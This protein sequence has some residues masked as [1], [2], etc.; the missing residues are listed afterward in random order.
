MK[1]SNKSLLIFAAVALVVAI[2]GIIYTSNQIEDHIHLTEDTQIKTPYDD[3]IFKIPTEI[4][5]YDPE[6]VTLCSIILCNTTTLN[7]DDVVISTSAHPDNTFTSTIDADDTVNILIPY[8]A[9]SDAT[10][11]SVALV[12]RKDMQDSNTTPL[13]SYHVF[14]TISLS[15]QSGA[16]QASFDIGYTDLSEI[17][18]MLWIY[19]GKIEAYSM[20]QYTMQNTTSPRYLAYKNPDKTVHEFTIQYGE[21]STTY[22]FFDDGNV[23]FKDWVH[24][25]SNI[26]S[27]IAF[28]HYLVDLQHQW[29]VGLD[30]VVIKDK[31]VFTAIPF[32]EAAIQR[33]TFDT[34]DLQSLASWLGKSRE[35]L[36]SHFG[37]PNKIS[38]DT[39]FS[40]LEYNDFIATVDIRNRIVSIELLTDKYHPVSVLPSEKMTGL[41]LS[42]YCLVE[43]I[44]YPSAEIF[45]DE[46]VP[47]YRTSVTFC[48]E[49]VSISYLWESEKPAV[50]ATEK[51]NRIIIHTGE[52]IMY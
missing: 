10:A 29:M 14:K 21:N 47:Y 45:K 39:A 3:I 1:Q 40:H 34:T 48:N 27:W 19:D 17:F 49:D 43:G 52:N 5:D 22:G 8:V 24:Q 31:D 9:D 6:N 46:A 2:S 13:D 16:M 7:F 35:E 15:K 42:K 11:Y 30:D 20:F 28:E 33:P 32:R 18:Y 51:F 26:H 23:M 38:G 12:D 50:A 4:P 44:E 37:E 36:T 41:Q 25:P